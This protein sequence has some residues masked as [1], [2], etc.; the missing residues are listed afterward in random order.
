MLINMNIGGTEKALLN[1]LDEIDNTQYNVTIL[2][3]E[4]YGGF[5]EDIPSRVNVRYLHGYNDIKAI[6]KKPP[7]RASIDLFKQGKLTNGLILS[8]SHLVYKI[9]N[10]RSTYFKYLLKDMENIS[11]VYDIA[12]AY[13]GPMDLISYYIINKVNAKRKIQWIH[14]D[15][16]KI[17]IDKYFLKKLYSKFDKICVVSKEAKEKL[18]DMIPSLSSKTEV[19]HNVVPKNKI[20]KM[21]QDEY[22]FDDEYNG[23][24]ILTVGRLSKEKGQDMIMPIVAKLKTDG[25]N[26][27]W[28]IIGDGNLRQ[29]CESLIKKYDIQK[30]CI[31]LGTKT[32]PYP[33]M[34]ECN[35]YVQPSRYEGYCVT[36]LEAKV[37]NKPIIATN[38]N[39]MK[40][41]M[42][43]NENFYIVNVNESDLYERIKKVLMM[44]S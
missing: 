27:R 33:Y 20:L 4:K 12:I 3:L 14:F 35:I 38:V 28:Y 31:L 26:I 22:G 40:E 29:E 18:N 15:I 25:F 8:L 19:F 36:T 43:D 32:N 41:Q 39:G 21:A 42:E 2:L 30:E 10:D 11:E 23:T 5:I 24:R 34:K 7:F 13:A 17:S 1:M 9:T 16:T 37:F 44:I 6:Y